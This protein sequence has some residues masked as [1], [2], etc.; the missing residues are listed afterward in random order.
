[1][2]RRGKRFPGS[3][4]GR[5]SCPAKGRRLLTP[6]SRGGTS[7]AVRVG[8]ESNALVGQILVPGAGTER[9]FRF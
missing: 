3:E 2:M 5:V 1:M 8:R 7:L 9:I 6:L 4:E